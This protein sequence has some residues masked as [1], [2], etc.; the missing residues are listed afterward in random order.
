MMLA[1]SI[2]AI[3][4]ILSGFAAAVVDPE[5][6]PHDAWVSVTGEVVSVHPDLFVLDYGEG[7][8]SVAMDKWQTYGDTWPLLDGD[9][10]T[11]YGEVD[12]GLYQDDRIEASSLHVEGLNTLFYASAADEKSLG[13]WV[14]DTTLE[15]GDLTYIGTV[16]T[17]SPMTDSFTIDT[18]GQALTVFTAQLPYDPLD[19]EGFQ[20]IEPGD[21]V[22][23]E[24]DVSA[25]FFG[26]ADLFA[27]S[28]VTLVD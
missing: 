16:A 27:D 24:G 25:D 13:H 5:E 8:I 18:D 17:V 9:K 10:V 6:M 21:R 23:V 11:V 4:A 7:E 26:E 19:D 15:V 28:I 20:R 3:T 12:A 1:A 2:A 22:S 14:L